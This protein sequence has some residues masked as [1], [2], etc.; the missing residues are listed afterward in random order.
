MIPATVKKAHEKLHGHA[1]VSDNV[2]SYADDP[3][4]V[5]KAE[6]AKKTLERVGLPGGKTNK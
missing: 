4:F 1:I 2:K 5:K 3:Y 6:Q